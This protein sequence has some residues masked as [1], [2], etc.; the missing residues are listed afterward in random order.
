MNVVVK[1]ILNITNDFLKVPSVICY[2]KPFLNYLNKKIS[3]LG[4]KT[5]LKENYLIVKPKENIN[6]KYLFS[7][8]ID[9]QGLVRNKDNKLEYA[10]FYFKKINNSEFK[11]DY[12]DFYLSCAQRYVNDNIISYS[13]KKTKITRY[14]LDWKNKLV[15]FHTLKNLK[16]E[17][18]G[19]D[20]KIQVKDNLF[21]GQI[22]NVIS[23]AVLFYLLKTTN[24][25][26]EIIFT[27]QEEIGK[28]YL[29]VLDYLKNRD[30]KLDIITLDTSPYEN[31]NEYEKGFLT[32]REGDENGTFNL[33]LVNKIE[34]F[35]KKQKVPIH[36]KSK[37]MGMTELGRISTESKG[38]FNGASIQLPTL[39]YHTNYETSTFESLGSYLKVIKELSK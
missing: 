22:D 20:S 3:K 12:Y 4:Y 28:S 7:A 14:N 9:R 30:S 37:E 31:F 18:F 27:T 19:F 17:V 6:S 5:I 35:L 29:N 1:E 21:F 36:F 16:G 34:E 25:N 23:V 26:C 8:H 13:K 24:F 10:A 32:L 38:K 33:D 11:K 2:E 39:N 15:T